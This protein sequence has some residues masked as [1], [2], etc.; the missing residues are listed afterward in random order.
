MNTEHANSHL[1]QQAVHS[2]SALR[3]EP[4]KQVAQHVQGKSAM[5]LLAGAP[6]R[7]TSPAA[8]APAGCSRATD[9]PIHSCRH[10]L[11]NQK[12]ITIHIQKKV[13]AIATLSLSVLQYCELCK[14]GSGSRGPFIASRNNPSRR[15]PAPAPFVSLGTLR[16]AYSKRKAVVIEGVI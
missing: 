4:P 1:L 2:C 9:L 6:A 11:V 16:K 13:S 12:N 5:V 15:F 14:F 3:F 7:M 8:E 10:A